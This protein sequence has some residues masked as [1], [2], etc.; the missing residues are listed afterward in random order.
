M[1]RRRTISSS[2]RHRCVM[3]EQ[4]GLPSRR[5]QSLSAVGKYTLAIGTLAGRRALARHTALARRRP[6]FGGCGGPRA[7]KAVLC[8]A[9]CTGMRTNV[10]IRMRRLQSIEEHVQLSVLYKQFFAGEVEVL[11]SLAKFWRRVNLLYTGGT[12]SQSTA[13][14]RSDCVR[15]RIAETFPKIQRRNL[16]DFPGAEGKTVTIGAGA[17]DAAGIGLRACDR[18]TQRGQVCEPATNHIKS[19]MLYHLSYRPGDSARKACFFNDS[20][21]VSRRHPTVS[22]RQ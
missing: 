16:K 17:R 3:Q 22:A 15:A 9:C 19:A 10:G 12:I 7:R 20:T 8:G 2:S 13:L 6:R 5:R 14:G 11:C 21:A 1:S 4:D 18:P